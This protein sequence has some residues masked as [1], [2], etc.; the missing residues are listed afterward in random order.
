MTVENLHIDDDRGLWIPPR[1]RK[2]DQQVVFRTPS[3]TIQHF[4]TEPL[5]AYY[6]MI[7]ESHFGDIDQLDG[8]RNPHLAPNRVSIKHTGGDAETFDVEGVVE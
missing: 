5:D 8:A 3:G 1:L 2:F 6:G 7:D 4:G